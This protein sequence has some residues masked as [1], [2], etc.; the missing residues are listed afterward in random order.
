MVCT[1][2]GDVLHSGAKIII[3][4]LNTRGKMGAGLAK[5]IK[6]EILSP[7]QYQ[8]Y[9][10]DCK[11][12][13]SDL[14]GFCRYDEVVIDGNPTKLVG[15]YAQNKTG[16][17]PGKIYT[18]YGALTAGLKNIRSVAEPNGWDVAIPYK[19]GCG[20]GGGDWTVVKNIIDRVFDGYPHVTIYEYHE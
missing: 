10:D 13:G 17:Q 19:I 6:E 11:K 20:L 9:V 15:I 8:N 3:H 1:I 14:L 2:S 4:Q 12:F 16:R 18:K 7:E 5:R